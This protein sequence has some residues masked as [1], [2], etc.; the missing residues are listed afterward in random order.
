MDALQFEIARFLAEKAVRGTRATY[1]QVGKAVGWSHPTGR[2]LGRNLEVILLYLRDNGLPPLTTIL[3]RRGEKYPAADAMTYIRGAL[4]NIDIDAAQKSAFDFDWSRV[5][6]LAPA[7]KGL[8]ANPDIWLTSFWGFEPANWGCIGFADETKLGRQMGG[9]GERPRFQRQM[10]IRGAG[11]PCGESFQKIGGWS[12]NYFQ[13]PM[14]APTR[15]S[16]ARAACD[17]PGSKPSARLSGQNPICAIAVTR[18]PRNSGLLSMPR[19]RTCD[20]TPEDP[21]DLLKWDE[22]KAEINVV[23][24][25]QTIPIVFGIAQKSCAGVES[26]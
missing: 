7:N 15:S 25:K 12:T 6:E 18:P 1:Q 20:A 10:A 19:F 21:F 24:P 16:L 3:V 17:Y 22:G 14:L 2:G 13:T 26:R 23:G 9:E 4:G 8:P 5:P 11:N